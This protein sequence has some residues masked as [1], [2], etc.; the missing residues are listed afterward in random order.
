MYFPNTL[1]GARNFEYLI[2]YF[3]TLGIDIYEIWHILIME[4]VQES[5]RG[6]RVTQGD[7]LTEILHSKAI[8]SS[9]WQ[10]TEFCP[11]GFWQELYFVSVSHLLS[12]YWT[13]S[14]REWLNLV[15]CYLIAQGHV[16]LSL[17]SRLHEWWVQG[18]IE[19]TG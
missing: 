3:L 11:L 13:G 9:S 1:N 15:Y 4:K 17:T 6:C 19:L 12:N 16:L 5:T 10:N 7:K 18:W 8:T 14:F 2:S